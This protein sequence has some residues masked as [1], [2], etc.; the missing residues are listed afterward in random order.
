VGTKLNPGAF[1]CYANAAPDEPMFVLLGRD[2]NAAAL[3]MLWAAM[4]RLDLDD[5]D[6]PKIEEAERCAEAM[7]AFC[8]KNLAG[9]SGLAQ[10]LAVLAGYVGAV[11]TIEQE[12]LLPL[13]MG[14]YRHVVKVRPKRAP[15]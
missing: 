2:K 6:F 4:R 14:S 13:A 12:P 7:M 5:A 15:A 11:V 1:D 10:G 9:V 3:V 8:K